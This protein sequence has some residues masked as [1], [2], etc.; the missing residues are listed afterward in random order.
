MIKYMSRYYVLEELDKILSS[1]FISEDCA[2]A[3]IQAKEDV[4]AMEKLTETIA[5]VPNPYDKYNN[6]GAYFG[7]ERGLKVVQSILE[8]GE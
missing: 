3:I 1:G 6:N 8:G 2:R 4:E 7:F 5:S